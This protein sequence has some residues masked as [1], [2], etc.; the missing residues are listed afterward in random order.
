MNRVLKLKKSDIDNLRPGQRYKTS[1]HNSEIEIV[2]VP[3]TTNDSKDICDFKWVSGPFMSYNHDDFIQLA[4]GT[5]EFLESLTS[6]KKM[7]KNKMILLTFFGEEM[8]SKPQFRGVFT[9]RFGALDFILKHKNDPN[10]VWEFYEVD[11]DPTK[12]R[13]DI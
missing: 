4:S 7:S 12:P 5:Q 13:K 9:S 2:N 11:V 6:S 10:T 3:S 1:F 8:N